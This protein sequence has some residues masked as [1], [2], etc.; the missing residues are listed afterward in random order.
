[1]TDI[2]RS[3]PDNHEWLGDGDVPSH[4]NVRK[5][6]WEDGRS[7]YL[8]DCLLSRLFV[9]LSRGH[10]AIEF[11]YDMMAEIRSAG[12]RIYNQYGEEVS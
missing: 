11:T 3:L 1:M 10:D 12:L 4:I 8:P 6:D 9:R 2:L 5:E 7:H